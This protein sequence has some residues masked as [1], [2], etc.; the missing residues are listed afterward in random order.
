M[1]SIVIFILFTF[2]LQIFAILVLDCGVGVLFAD[3]LHLSSTFPAAICILQLF[4]DCSVA[5]NFPFCDTW[6]VRTR[7]GGFTIELSCI[8]A[9]YSCWVVREVVAAGR[10]PSF[11]IYCSR[12]VMVRNNALSSAMLLGFRPRSS[13]NSGARTDLIATTYVFKRFT[14]FCAF[15]WRLLICSDS[16]WLC[17]RDRF[18]I[19]FF[20]QC[21]WWA[22]DLLYQTILVELLLI[23]KDWPLL[24]YYKQHHL[25]E[26][27]HCLPNRE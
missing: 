19:D 26:C 24:Y 22:R 3:F 18:S 17:Y 6:F 5:I 8:S 16:N 20:Y 9:T 27:R 15:I 10:C 14:S 7:L 23:A 21:V 13:V 2:I 1:Y 4:A 11:S 25:K 12:S